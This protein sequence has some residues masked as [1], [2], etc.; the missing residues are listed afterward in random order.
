MTRDRQP[1]PVYIRLA[2]RDLKQNIVGSFV[3]AIV[4]GLAIAMTL[5]GLIDV[6][7]RPH[8]QRVHFQINDTSSHARLFSGSTVDGNG[9]ALHAL[10]LDAQQPEKINDSMTSVGLEPLEVIRAEV[11]FSDIPDP[12]TELSNAVLGT[13]NFLYDFTLQ[14]S[15]ADWT[16]ER[17]NTDITM[18]EG[19]LPRSAQEIAVNTQALAPYAATSE[20]KTMEDSALVDAA[21]TFIST[22]QTKFALGSTLQGEIGGTSSTLTV[23]GWYSS[24]TFTSA[25]G[26]STLSEDDTALVHQDILG[27]GSAL[28]D[29]QAIDLARDFSTEQ[30]AEWSHWGI[31]NLTED[32]AV[33]QRAAFAIPLNQSERESEPSQYPSEPSVQTALILAGFISLISIPLHWQN[34]RRRSQELTQLS[35]AGMSGRQQVV[36]QL[37]PA[38]AVGLGAA[39]IGLALGLLF[40]DPIGRFWA[41]DLMPLTAGRSLLLAVTAAVA[42]GLIPT[43][44]ASIIPQIISRVA[45]NSELD[46]EESA[47]ARKPIE[48]STVGTRSDT[49]GESAKSR[50]QDLML[51]VMLMALGIIIACLTAAGESNIAPA[52]YC[53][54]TMMILVGTYYWFS[55]LFD[56]ISSAVASK[57]VPLRLAAR[58]L[59][60][61]R[62][63]SI[64]AAVAIALVS[65]LGVTIATIFKQHAIEYGPDRHYTR[66]A[67]IIASVL[68]VLLLAILYVVS[69]RGD[70]E[71][72]NLRTP[73]TQQGLHDE[74]LRLIDGYRT[75]ILAVLGC[76]TGYL[77]G[78][79]V[80]AAALITRITNGPSL[81]LEPLTF[82]PSSATFVAVIVPILAAFYIGQLAGQRNISLTNANA[83]EREYAGT[84]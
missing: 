10:M 26:V 45:P 44:I 72:R 15:N 8:A 12:N 24:E 37:I 46:D 18:I 42:L 65:M 79:G 36:T 21:K 71:L 25:L 51:P 6:Y 20:G 38:I 68:T 9:Q 35:R 7:Q 52:A 3:L 41:S 17:P 4:L 77:L 58:E 11:S 2:L 22:A 76:V 69:L 62:V 50:I 74:E 23:V 55:R 63:S 66:D 19:R 53:I 27:Y 56:L 14:V 84:H 32:P 33:A 47:M 30:Q 64:N 16:D 60:L 31:R 48:A 59:C 54:A 78:T 49:S 43:L 29:N 67:L 75:L 13:E 5:P 61:Q 73:L 40:L 83:N 39:I 81:K 34:R 80:A 70:T 57:R 28:S 1:L 82:V